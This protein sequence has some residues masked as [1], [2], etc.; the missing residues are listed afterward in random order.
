[1][2]PCLLPSNPKV[3]SR[4]VK[5]LPITTL[6]LCDAGTKYPGLSSKRLA[7]IPRGP[8]LLRRAPWSTGGG[9]A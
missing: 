2:D 4:S 1:M 7:R 6:D 3:K 8:E 5:G 9:A